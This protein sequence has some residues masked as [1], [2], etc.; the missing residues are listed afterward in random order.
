MK[1]WIWFAE[2]FISQYNF[3]F[4]LVE[5]IIPSLRFASFISY[6]KTELLAKIACFFL[7]VQMITLF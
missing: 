1:D 5:K 4:Y 6:S 3:A 2:Q 7:N